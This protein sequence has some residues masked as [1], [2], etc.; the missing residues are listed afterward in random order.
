MCVLKRTPGTY[1]LLDSMQYIPK[2][3]SKRLCEINEVVITF[4]CNK[5]KEGTHL[6]PFLMYDVSFM[7]YAILNDLPSI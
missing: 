5:R 1:G 6:V 2:K 4:K 3:Y 7:L